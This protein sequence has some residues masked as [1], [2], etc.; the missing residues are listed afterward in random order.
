MAEHLEARREWQH[1]HESGDVQLAGPQLHPSWPGTVV[2]QR[3]PHDG[4]DQRAGHRTARGRGSLQSGAGECLTLLVTGTYGSRPPLGDKR[5][6]T[7]PMAPVPRRPR[8]EPTRRIRQHPSQEHSPVCNRRTRSHVRRSRRTARSEP[9][10]CDLDNRDLGAFVAWYE[11]ARA[12]PLTF[13]SHSLATSLRHR[14]EVCG[15]RGRRDAMERM[16]TRA[17][18]GTFAVD[19]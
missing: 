18:A 7:E 4:D 6:A 19:R 13:M 2:S 8:V 17:G 14:A 12:A 10:L 9:L 1:A 16:S 11:P 5:P 3:L 15:M